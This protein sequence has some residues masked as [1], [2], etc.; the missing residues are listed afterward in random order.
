MTCLTNMIELVVHLYS[1]KYTHVSIRPKL[2][3]RTKIT[4]EID[5]KIN[6]DKGKR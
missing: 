1:F 2:D 4:I 5:N 6:R 3:M